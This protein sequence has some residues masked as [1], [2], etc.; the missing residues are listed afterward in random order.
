MQRKRAKCEGCGVL[1]PPQCLVDCL[2]SDCC[3]RSEEASPPTAMAEA[4]S[5]ATI[6]KEEEEQTD[7]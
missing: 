1:L 2:C 5:L 7:D 3:D 6:R 4:F